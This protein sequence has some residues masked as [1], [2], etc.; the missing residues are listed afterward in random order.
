MR[1]CRAQLHSSSADFCQLNCPSNVPGQFGTEHQGNRLNTLLD[2]PERL[3]GAQSC[4]NAE[5]AQAHWQF[6]PFRETA[7]GHPS[8]SNSRYRYSQ[9]GTTE[10]AANVVR[11][12]QV[13]VYCTSTRELR[14]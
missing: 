8:V 12:Y 3:T 9:I 14:G 7:G 11:G 4:I 6:A 2:S 10:S 5:L 13:H 1:P